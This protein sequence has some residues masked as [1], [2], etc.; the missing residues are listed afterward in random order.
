[1]ELRV[2]FHE[3]RVCPLDTGTGGGLRLLAI[4]AQAFQLLLGPCFVAEGPAERYI[5]G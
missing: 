4:I 2:R 3:Q 1:M 5:F